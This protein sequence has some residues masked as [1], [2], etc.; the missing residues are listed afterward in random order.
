MENKQIPVVSGKNNVENDLLISFIHAN[1]RNMIIKMHKEKI[2]CLAIL[3]YLS[4][5]RTGKIMGQRC[6]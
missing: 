1:V 2:L 3:F 5:R 6:Y 4:E